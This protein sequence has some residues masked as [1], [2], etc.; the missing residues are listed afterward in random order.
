[1]ETMSWVWL[2][3]IVATA[4]FEIITTDL[5]SIWFTFGAI[6]PFI[7]ATTTELEIA[8]QI[9]IFLVISAILVA[10]LRKITMKYLFK[11]NNNDKTNL[12]A[13][14][15][16][17]YR[18]LEKTDFETIGKVKIKDLEWSVVGD[19][20]QTIKKGKVVEV[21]KISGNKLIVR[22]SK[23]ESS[24]KKEDSKTETIN[25]PVS[26]KAETETKENKKK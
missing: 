20:Q 4:I 3:I 26:A 18:L 24:D 10:C 13:L 2:G 6:I 19:K 11:R 14:I 5:V 25:N 8:W 9:A 21:V 16:Q 1:M 7:L 23:D 15:G 22:E 17:K 12:D